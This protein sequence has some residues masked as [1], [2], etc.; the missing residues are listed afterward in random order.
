MYRPTFA[1][2]V[3]LTGCT[4]CPE[5]SGAYEL[6]VASPCDSYI[7]SGTVAW[8]SA[9]PGCTASSTADINDTGMPGE[10]ACYAAEWATACGTTEILLHVGEEEDLDGNGDYWRGTV[11]VYEN[12]ALVST[13]L[14]DLR[15]P[16]S[17]G[18]DE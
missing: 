2:L 15:R 13:C 16:G 4:I 14:A 8:G 5:P 7:G 1:F 9:A 6:R 18:W 11:F 17:R 12:G 3:L 10:H